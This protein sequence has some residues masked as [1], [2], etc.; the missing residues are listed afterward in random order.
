MEL[1]IN[2]K[3]YAEYEMACNTL[4]LKMIIQIIEGA[5]N[6]QQSEDLIINIIQC[7]ENK[8]FNHICYLNI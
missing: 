1:N 6:E 7:I 4:Y 2:G 5:E 3:V 8:K